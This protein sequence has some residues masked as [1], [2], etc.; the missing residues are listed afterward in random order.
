MGQTIDACV[1]LRYTTLDQP[2]QFV[3]LSTQSIEDFIAVAAG[4]TGTYSVPPGSIGSTPIQFL[5]LP[6]TSPFAGV[7]LYAIHVNTSAPITGTLTSGT[8]PA[9]YTVSG[10]DISS[11]AFRLNPTA[12]LAT[13]WSIGSQPKQRSLNKN[14]QFGTMNTTLPT[15]FNDIPTAGLILSEFTDAV[16][17]DTNLIVFAP[18]RLTRVEIVTSN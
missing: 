13:E 4:G 3:V 10:W 6:P 15:T 12:P 1:Y 9:T 11:F 17:F 7:N 2:W 18:E 8:G 5:S 16:N 14:L